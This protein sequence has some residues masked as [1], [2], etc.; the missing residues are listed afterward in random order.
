MIIIQDTKEKIPWNFLIYDKC[1]SQLCQSLLTGDYTIQGYE[2]DIIIERKRSVGELANN[3]GKKNKQFNN[4]LERMQDFRFRY[5]VCEFPIT[6]VSIFPQDSGIPK[7][8]WSKLRMNGQFILS[9]IN[10]LCERYGVE[11]HFCENTESAERLSYNLMIEAK[12]I[13]DGEK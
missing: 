9:T 7:K 4:E 12:D 1:Q 10:N 11:L 8:L 5:L 2:S 3:L 6:R 13:I